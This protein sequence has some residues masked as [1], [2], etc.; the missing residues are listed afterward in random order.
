MLVSLSWP[1]L[2]QSGHA[3]AL[4]GEEEL[5]HTSVCGPA[6]YRT[7]EESGHFRKI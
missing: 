6:P 3:L 4:A 2:S 1:E 5:T 7:Y